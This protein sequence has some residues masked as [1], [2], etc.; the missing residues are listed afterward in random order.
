VPFSAIYSQPSGI[1][2]FQG[3]F[4][5]FNYGSYLLIALGL[6]VWLGPSWMR[7]VF[8][9]EFLFLCAYYMIT[10]TGAYGLHLPYFQPTIISGEN[11]TAYF[12]SWPNNLQEVVGWIAMGIPWLLPKRF[13]ER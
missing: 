6:V 11:A 4:F 3:D 12:L 9:L 7:R 2:M 13:F 8:L 10:F 1:G 5:F